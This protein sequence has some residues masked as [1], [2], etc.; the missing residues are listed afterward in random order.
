[1]TRDADSVGHLLLQWSKA[2]HDVRKLWSLQE[3]KRFYLRF[4]VWGNI[5][6]QRDNVLLFLQT[7]GFDDDPLW[8]CGFEPCWCC[9][10]NETFGLMFKVTEAPE[11]RSPGIT[12]CCRHQNG[13]AAGLGLCWSLGAELR[14]CW[15]C[16]RRS[17]SACWRTAVWR[18]RAGRTEEEVS[19]EQH[20]NPFLWF[21]FYLFV[22]LAGRRPVG[23]SEAAFRCFCG[24]QLLNDFTFCCVQ[25]FW[26][27]SLV[28]TTARCWL[29]KCK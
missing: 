25:T 3:G 27:P 29:F 28:T 15:R 23:R 6:F 20:W 9:V 1:M 21:L 12:G 16:L 14:L 2:C 10:S 24:A 4:K 19:R 11:G 17:A 22:W 8:G 18:G 7:S 13:N 26:F 5:W